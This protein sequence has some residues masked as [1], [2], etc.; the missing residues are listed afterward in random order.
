[1]LTF[2][3]KYLKESAIFKQHKLATASSV[4]SFVSNHMGTAGMFSS[5]SKVALG[6][7]E[8]RVRRSQQTRR[9]T[10]KGS[11]AQAEKENQEAE[12]AKMREELVL[13]EELKKKLALI[14]CAYELPIA[15]LLLLPESYG[16]WEAD[17]TAMCVGPQHVPL[18]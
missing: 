14:E 15:Q 12:L 1:M 5:R 18:L 4:F 9:A 11:K 17:L 3:N 6:E 13:I 8:L 2:L 16:T 7:L 10:E